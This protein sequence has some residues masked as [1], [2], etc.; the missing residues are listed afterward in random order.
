M[1]TYSFVVSHDVPTTYRIGAEDMLRIRDREAA[2]ALAHAI[3]RD[4]AF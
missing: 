3:V 4:C 1:R 2:S